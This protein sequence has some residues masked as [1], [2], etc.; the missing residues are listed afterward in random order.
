MNTKT[1]FL[2]ALGAG[3]LALCTPLMAQTAE[4]LLAVR[5]SAHA[6]LNAHDVE[7]ALTYFTEDAILDFAPA[8]A[9]AVGTG[10]IRAF[11]EAEF[12]SFPDWQA[13]DTHILA[14]DTMIV[15]EQIINATHLGIWNGVPPT[16]NPLQLPLIAVL[17]CEGDKIKRLTAY[18]DASTEMMQFGLAPIPTMPELVPSFVLP[19]PEPTELTPMDAQAEVLARWNSQDLVGYAKMFRP[20]AECFLAPV[21]MATDRKAQVAMEELYLASFSDRRAETIR[22]VDLGGGWIMSEVVFVG[23]HTGAYFGVPPSGNL[24]RLRGAILEQFDAD[25]LIACHH[26]YYDNLTLM[27]QITAEEPS[28]PEGMVFV[29]IPGGTFEMGD[30]F[31]DGVEN[32]RPVH[33]VTVTPFRLSKY[34]VTNA[35]YCEYL[36]SALAQGLIEIQGGSVYASSVLGSKKYLSTIAASDASLITFADGEFSP[37]IHGGISMA[38]HPVVAVTWYGAKAFCDYYG[39]RLPTEAEWE[40]A[41]RG[42]QYSP[43]FKYPW[44]SN[45]ATVDQ[46]NCCFS[47]PVG[48]PRNPYTA[49]VDFYAE[50]GYGLCGMA[51]NVTE[52]CTDWWDAD[53]YK[54]SPQQDPQGPLYG[55]RRSLRGGDW[56]L[57]SADC[58]ITGRGGRDLGW[59]CPYGAVGFRPAL[60]IPR[61]PFQHG[62]PGLVAHWGLDETEGTI[63]H[64]YADVGDASVM[65]GARWRPTAGQVGGALELDGIDDFMT[66][67]LVLDP[68][69]GSFSVF[70]WIKGGA[71][72]QVIL[73]QDKGANW[74]KADAITGVLTTELK[75]AR[76]GPLASS[77]IVVDGVWHRIGLVWDGS[78]RILYVDDTEVARDTVPSLSGTPG[79][80]YV[81]AGK[82]LE[83]GTFWSGLIDDIRVYDRAIVP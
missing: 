55:A 83:P 40:C 7:L 67:N 47:D 71:P 12:T 26:V 58:R 69:E 38:N 36:N 61:T 54:S 82:G 20:D 53:Y 49:P 80:L 42:G 45:T 37:R 72:G 29:G 35:Q 48:L 24:F 65:D 75:S 22:I 79:G 10:Q 4:E 16:G 76:G 15:A 64:N 39:Y 6:A 78:D 32:E 52:W 41:A 23:T 70:A 68:R 50:Y 14:T 28:G 11:F 17:D 9:P 56:G 46:L 57:S 33:R 27:T 44:G 34:E 77:A 8:P 21:G 62:E 59:F 73:S 19:D 2:I 5:S 66:T 31:G 60:D 43:Y 81:G 18:A 3:L 30:H 13:V 74:L 25:G 1:R 51:G 63:A